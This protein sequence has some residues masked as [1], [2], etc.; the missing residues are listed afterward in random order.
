MDK[1][2]AIAESHKAERKQIDE[3]GYTGGGEIV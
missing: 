2:Y 1:L 3:T